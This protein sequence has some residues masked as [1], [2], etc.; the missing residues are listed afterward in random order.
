MKRVRI[1]IIE[2]EVI[3]AEDLEVAISNIGYKMVDSAVTAKDAI[4][5]A[6][7][8]KPDLILMDIILGGKADG[9]DASIEIKEKLSI[10]IV[11]LTS[12]SDIKLMDRAKVT[13][14][15]AYILKPFQ[16]RQLFASIEMALMQVQ[17]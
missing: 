8:L 13:E 3:V 9:I 7:E 15:Y 2:D 5:K 1:L 12:Y 16:E 10:H 11:F 14:P 4:E 17:F 6:V